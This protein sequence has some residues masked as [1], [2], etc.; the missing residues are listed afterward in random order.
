MSSQN[1]VSCNETW[2]SS[3]DPIWPGVPK[4][5]GRI[6]CRTLNPFACF[7]PFALL[8]LV[9]GVVSSMAPVPVA[10]AQAAPSF[11]TLV[12]VPDIH[13]D[14][15]DGSPNTLSRAGW[16]AAR[17]FIEAHYGDSVWNIRG[18]VDLGDIVSENNG[19]SPGDW[20]TVMRHFQHFWD[21]GLPFVVA[22]GNHDTYYPVQAAWDNNWGVMIKSWSTF[23]PSIMRLAANDY[24]PYANGGGA[25]TPNATTQYARLDIPTANGIVK[26]ALAAGGMFTSSAALAQIKAQAD[27]DTDRNVVFGTHMFL[28]ATY[29]APVTNGDQPCVKG[30]SLCMSANLSGFLA[31]DEMWASMKTWPRLVAIVNGHTH[32]EYGNDGVHSAQLIGAAGNIVQALSTHAVATRGTLIL[33]KFRTDNHTIEWYSWKT[34][35]GMAD[36][37][38]W[39]VP[40]VTPW[41]PLVASN[42]LPRLNAVVNAAS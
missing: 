28:G 34:M 37:T 6:E 30:T 8:I 2:G 10:V 33:A 42:D 19:V 7:F 22:A 1:A 23:F 9:M 14:F 20:V 15:L 26:M 41:V 29:T 13:W 21:L 39:G 36:S 31:G 40:L 4:S 16:N 25:Y 35:D 3:V 11:F 32:G 27:L 38:A 17:A 5:S 24:F 12:F 18:G